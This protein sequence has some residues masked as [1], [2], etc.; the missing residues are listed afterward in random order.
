MVTVGRLTDEQY[1]IYD[2]PNLTSRSH[3]FRLS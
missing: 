3:T 2:G 1:A